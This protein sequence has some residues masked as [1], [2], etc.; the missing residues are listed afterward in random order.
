MKISLTPRNGI[1]LLF[2]SFFM[3]ETHE[4]AHTGVGRLICGCWGRRNFNLWGICKGCGDEQPLSILSTYAGP[5]YSF[6]IIWVGYYLLSKPSARI[7]S[8]GLA[9]IVAS[10]PF[11]RIITPL[12]GGGDEV[13][14]LNTHLDN[15]ALAW[16]LG[17]T[18]VLLLAIPPVVGVWNTIRNRRKALWM[19]GLLLVPFLMTGAVV[20]GILQNLLLENGFLSDYWILGSPKLVTAWFFFCVVV[21]V[22]TGNSLP[23]LLQPAGGRDEK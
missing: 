4:L 22:F 20:F 17:L 11:S 5:L 9:L 2:L 3:Q 21:L 16:A 15:H 13:Y 12:F 8:I 23:T 6:S 14:A 19:T 18:I 1:A 10:M 7:K